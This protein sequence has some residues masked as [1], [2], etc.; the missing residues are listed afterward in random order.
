MNALS[1]R[2]RLANQEINWVKHISLEKKGY[3]TDMKMFRS[4]NR[5]HF[6]TRAPKTKSGLGCR[7][8]VNGDLVSDPQALLAVWADH[9]HSQSRGKYHEENGQ[10]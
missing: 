6:C 10:T 1:M 9:F 2:W 8:R 3:S 7:Q 4:D 5:Y